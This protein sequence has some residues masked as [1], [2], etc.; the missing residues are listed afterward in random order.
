MKPRFNTCLEKSWS[1]GVKNLSYY[2]WFKEEL[3]K[4]DSD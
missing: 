1:N 4:D 2:K 3:E